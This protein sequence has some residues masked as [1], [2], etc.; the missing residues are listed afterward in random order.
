MAPRFETSIP[1]P[2]MLAAWAPGERTVFHATQAEADT[3]DRGL[4]MLGRGRSRRRAEPI[5]GSD[6]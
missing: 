2:D 5:E 6:A 3:R 1:T 4:D